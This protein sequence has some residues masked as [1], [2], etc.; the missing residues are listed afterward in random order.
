[1]VVLGATGTGK[2]A[3]AIQ[4]ALELGGEIVNADSRY[5]YRGMDIGT[6]KPTQAE[7]GGVPHDLLDIL[8][9]NDQFSVALYLDLAYPSIDDI[10]TRSHL[11]I[12]T[13]GT[14]QYLRALIEGWSAPAVPPDNVLRRALEREPSDALHR[15]LAAVDPESAARIDPRNRGV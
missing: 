3:L 12:V 4:L 8:E 1:M 14:P 11:P 2:T 6:A 15:Q 10:T 7:Q 5:F 9:P 13:G